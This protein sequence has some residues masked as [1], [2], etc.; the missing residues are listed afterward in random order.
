MNENFAPVL[1][2]DSKKETFFNS[3]TD[4]HSLQ[5]MLAHIPIEIMIAMAA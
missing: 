1:Q 2:N 5:M 4:I 3:S